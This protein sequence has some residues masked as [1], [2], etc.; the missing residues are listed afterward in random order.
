M[1]KFTFIAILLAA[2]GMLVP[3]ARDTAAQSPPVIYLVRH[4]ETGGGGDD[5]A[6]SPEGRA[7][8]A[9]LARMLAGAGLT[10]VYTTDVA[11]TR[12]TAGPVAEAAAVDVRTYE[13]TGLREL[14]AELRS[15]PGRHLVVGHSNTTPAL[16]QLLGGDPG[17]PIAED[18]YGR[19]YQL[20]LADDGTHTAL[21]GY[22]GGFLAEPPP[23]PP[24]VEARTEDVA[25]VEAI[26]DALYDVISGGVGEPRDWDRMRSLF[27]PG[28]R[29]VPVQ[30][31]PDGRVGYREMTVEDYIRSSGPVIERIGFTERELAQRVD[32]FG[33]VAQVFSTYEG[34]REGVEEPILRGLNSIQLVFDGRRWWVASLAWSPE[35]EDLPIPAEFLP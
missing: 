31:A 6:L 12:G 19:V 3:D 16:V 11:R 35:R 14:A 8:A 27:L 24:A 1:G 32:R 28:A 15:R 30:R 21:L 10:S 23:A 22:P 9:R 25:S 18:E 20:T 26:T 34:R 7:R 4:A 29:M 5:P 33:D 13:P 17:G 2:L